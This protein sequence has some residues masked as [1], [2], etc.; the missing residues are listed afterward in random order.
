MSGLEVVAVVSAVI[1]A[2]HGASELLKRVQAKRRRSRL[3]QQ[4][5]EA[6]QLHDSLA[7]G[8]QQIGLRYAQDLRALG[9]VMRIG[10]V[11]ACNQLQNITIL[12]QGEVINSLQIA[13]QYDNAVLNL[14]L[15]H[16]ASITNKTATLQTLHLLKQRLLRTMPMPMP[17]PMDRQLQGLVESLHR[18]SSSPT[19]TTMPG[20]STFD[21]SSFAA[22]DT[23]LPAAVSLPSPPEQGASKHGVITNYLLKRS[24]SSNSSSSSTSVHQALR[25]ASASDHIQ[26]SQA[27]QQLVN[28]ARGTEDDAAIMQEIHHLVHLYHDLSVNQTSS[29]AWANNTPW[30]PPLGYDDTRRDTLISLHAGDMDTPSPAQEALHMAQNLSP[31]VDE[32]GYRAYSESPLIDPSSSTSSHASPHDN[33]L[34]PP[35]PPPPPPPKHSAR[36]KPASTSM[37]SNPVSPIA[38]CCNHDGYQP[39]SDPYAQRYSQAIAPLSPHQSARG[40]SS[41][42]TNQA[43]YSHDGLRPLGES[44]NLLNHSPYAATLHQDALPEVRNQRSQPTSAHPPSTPPFEQP[45]QAPQ[46]AVSWPHASAPI[47]MLPALRINT[48]IRTASMP[49]PSTPGPASGRTTDG[50]PCKANHYWGFCKGAWTIREDAQRGL[51]LRP[52][53]QGLYNTRQIW[54]CTCC[55]FQGRAFPAPQQQQQQPASDKKKKN[56]PVTVVDPRIVTSQSGVRYKW[57]FLAKCHAEEGNYGCVFCC[58]EDRVSGVYG[59]VEPLMDHIAQCHAGGMSEVVRRKARCVVGSKSPGEHETEWDVHIPDFARVTELP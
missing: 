57:I 19:G 2:F 16:E 38:P 54:K 10:D 11:L 55:S 34:A 49:Q 3:P 5:F 46:P 26:F 8:E 42:G 58:L 29:N 53:P 33:P 51:S 23:Y 37:P 14:T 39:S 6:Q 45:R 48:R 41:P 12:M 56:K 9:H 15:L 24:S 30:R 47:S 4:E 35:P 32:P 44:G 40:A 28:N 17:M 22:A 31:T 27:F 59:G 43:H 7:S 21:P 50:R 1:S 18:Q 25:Q 52:H 20:T 36:P 13:A